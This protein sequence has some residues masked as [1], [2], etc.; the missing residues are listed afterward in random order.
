M[1]VNKISNRAV[2][3][4]STSNYGIKESIAKAKEEFFNNKNIKFS[5]G[6]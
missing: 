2:E 6:N 1:D 3:I 5:G 4:Y